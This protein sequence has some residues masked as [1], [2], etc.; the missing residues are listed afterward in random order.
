MDL[1]VQGEQGSSVREA[2]LSGNAGKQATRSRK[3]FGESFMLSGMR[4]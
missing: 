4:H 1:N 3:G 2:M